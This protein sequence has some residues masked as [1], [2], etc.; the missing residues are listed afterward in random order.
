MDADGVVQ[1]ICGVV[2]VPEEDESWFSLRYEKLGLL[3]G[4]AVMV[5]NQGVFGLVRSLDVLWVSIP[6]GG[7]R[8]CC[9]SRHSGRDGTRVHGM[10][11][12]MRRS[13]QQSLWLLS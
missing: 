11:P 1:T 4:Y 10:E 2:E 6:A 13:R 3:L 8:W 12:S 9:R 7:G 5:C